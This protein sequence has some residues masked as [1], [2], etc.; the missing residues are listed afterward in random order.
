MSEEIRLNN[1]KEL[2]EKFKKSE[3]DGKFSMI[4]IQSAGDNEPSIKD[5]SIKNNGQFIVDAFNSDLSQNSP[6]EFL[7]KS[8]IEKLEDK[9][10]QLRYFLGGLKYIRNGEDQQCSYWTCDINCSCDAVDN[11]SR[12]NAVRNFIKKHNLTN[13]RFLKLSYN[14]LI[15]AVMKYKG[16]YSPLFIEL[17]SVLR[18]Y[19]FTKTDRGKIPDN[20]FREKELE[21]L[22]NED[23]ENNQIIIAFISKYNLT[24]ADFITFAKISLNYNVYGLQV[25]NPD[26]TFISEIK[27]ITHYY[28][29][30]VSR[31][32]IENYRNEYKN[33]QETA[34]LMVDIKSAQKAYLELMKELIIK[35]PSIANQIIAEELNELGINQKKK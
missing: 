8:E 31:E 32:Y 5:E 15:G 30:N 12:L 11:D 16:E 29:L 9:N 27:N 19:H 2:V 1:G 35:N 25:T 18:P 22:V 7:K 28:K 20:D 34:Q 4:K 23:Y 33:N 24:K 6:K 10:L 13:E 26:D 17:D 21:N 14:Y 3:F